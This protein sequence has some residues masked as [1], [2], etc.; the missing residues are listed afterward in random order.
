MLWKQNACIT[1]FFR[2]SNS[3]QVIFEC[4]FEILDLAQ[5][6]ELNYKP[7]STIPKYYLIQSNKLIIS[8]RNGFKK[9][10]ISKCPVALQFELYLP[11]FQLKQESCFAARKLVNFRTFFGLSLYASTMQLCQLNEQRPFATLTTLKLDCTFFL[12]CI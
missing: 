5:Y 9:C 7:K 3:K 1:I 6:D 2:W 8:L 4:P 11:L 12:F 10:L